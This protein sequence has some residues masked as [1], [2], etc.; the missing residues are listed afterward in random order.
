MSVLKMM[1]VVQIASGKTITFNI[2]I[3]HLYVLFKAVVYLLFPR[4]Q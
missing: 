3:I 1:K 4:V 2:Q